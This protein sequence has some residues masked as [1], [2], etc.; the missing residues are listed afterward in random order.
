MKR[1]INDRT[2]LNYLL[3]S[4]NVDLLKNICRD[5]ELKG[6]SKLKKLEL[7][8]F[9]LDSLSDEELKELLTAKELEIISAEINLAIKF[10]HIIKKL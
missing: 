2:Y 9:I 7:I 10:T 3:Q 5:F 6:Y 8:D 1:Q 4:L